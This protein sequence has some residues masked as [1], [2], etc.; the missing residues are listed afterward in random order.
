MGWDELGDLDELA[1]T[2]EAFKVAMGA[3][4]P[5]AKAGTVS[6]WAGQLFRFVH[7]AQDGDVVVYRE[8]GGGPV[9]IG[10]INGP[11][12][13]ADGEV[14]VQRRP[15]KWEAVGLAAGDFP[16][17][18]RFE[19]GAFLTWFSIKR[20]PDT[21]TNAL[22]GTARP[23]KPALT[24]EAEGVEDQLDAAAIDQATRDFVIERLATHFK[25]HG[26][27]R[28]T[29]HV[30]ELLGYATT[31]SPPGK[32]YG[33]D[34]VAHHGVLGLEPPLIKVQVKS[35]EGSIGSPPVAQLLGRLAR[36]SPSWCS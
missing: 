18:P 24:D 32:D 23:L 6:Q 7:D 34:I 31:V 11:Y 4:Y 2:K 10:T 9:N 15:V 25:G 27:A 35:S 29:A 3:A 16:T 19:L 21:W 8:R 13:R 33:I 12:R 30:L 22:G 14:Y 36:S 28:L 17:G 20:Y 1:A 5:D 26:F